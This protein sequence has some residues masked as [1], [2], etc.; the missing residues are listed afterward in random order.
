MGVIDYI[1]EG[2][3]LSLLSGNAVSKVGQTADTVLLH[4]NS[5]QGQTRE[6]SSREF[7]PH[8]RPHTP[9]HKVGLAK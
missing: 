8:P 4:C 5:R 3:T 7:R 6:E 2:V 1:T 9:L